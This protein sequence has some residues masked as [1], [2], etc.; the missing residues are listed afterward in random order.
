MCSTFKEMRNLI[1]AGNT[2]EDKSKSDALKIMVNT[3]YGANANPYIAYGD[4]GCGYYYHS[5]ARWLILSAVDIIRGRYGED[6]VVYVHTDGINTNVD[7]DE[8]VN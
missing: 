8:M 4:M 7:V 2:K 3:F 6:A 1:K 5:M